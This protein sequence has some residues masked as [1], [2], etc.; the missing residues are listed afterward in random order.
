MPDAE[1]CASLCER[2]RVMTADAVVASD[3]GQFGKANSQ[4]QILSP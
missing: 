2:D 4:L 1:A 3:S